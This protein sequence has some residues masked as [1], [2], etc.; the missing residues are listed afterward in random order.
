MGFENRIAQLL[1]KHPDVLDNPSREVMIR[2]GVDGREAIVSANGALAT[3]TPPESTGRSPKDTYIVR[4]KES[5]ASIDWDSPN[6]IPMDP[7]TFDMIME[8]ALQALSAKSGCT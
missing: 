1:E 4:R 5:E 3:W 8:D 2:E 7:D 6:N